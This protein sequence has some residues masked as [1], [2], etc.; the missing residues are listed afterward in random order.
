LGKHAKVVVVSDVDG[1]I[2][3]RRTRAHAE[4][5]E[6]VVRLRQAGVPLVL[7]SSRTRAELER[8]RQELSVADPFIAENGG[9]IFVPAG[10]FRLPPA[11]TVRRGA[12]DVMELGR[13][14]REV[15]QRLLAVAARVGVDVTTF[16]DM[17]VQRVAAECGLSL[18]DARLAKL[19]EYDEPFRLVEADADARAKLRRSLR[20]AG[21]RCTSGGQ[22]DHVTLATDK[23][24]ATAL[25]RRFY[26][27]AWGDVT[28]VGLGGGEDDVEL[29]RAVD[30]PIVV[31]WDDAD[32]TATV[33]E[34]VRRARV[35]TLEGPAGWGEAVCALLDD[36][37]P[38]R[39]AP[40]GF[41]V[42]RGPR[43]RTRDA[44]TAG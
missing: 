43:G 5:D 38:F 24:V 27:R 37:E 4:A 6:A 28:M 17:S 20:S 21:V 11:G 22:F 32:A 30:V 39:P 7:C 26:A 35:T 16:S 40:S 33:V 8:F 34:Q 18:A 44:G 36:A 14:H 2:V 9:A 29:L 3:D 42:F 25:L 15:L 1:C 12:Y 31:R 13:P 23:G 19:R 41:F 10:A